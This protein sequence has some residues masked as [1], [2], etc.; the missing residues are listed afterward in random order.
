MEIIKMKLNRKTAAVISQKALWR[1][2]DN[3]ENACINCTLLISIRFLYVCVKFMQLKSLYHSCRVLLFFF[4][5]I[6]CVT[7]I[8]RIPFIL[9]KIYYAKGQE[10]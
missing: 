7:K 3:V 6:S 5:V 4:F 2:Q 8:N 10:R 9:H 1:F